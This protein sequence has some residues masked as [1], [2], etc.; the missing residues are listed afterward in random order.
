MLDKDHNFVYAHSCFYTGL[1]HVDDCEAVNVVC[2]VTGNNEGF[3]MSIFNQI[4]TKLISITEAF[5]NDERG[6]TAIEYAV[7]AVAVAAVVLAVFG[8]GADNP[9]QS[10]LTEAMDTVAGQVTTAEETTP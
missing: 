5:K 2:Q 4:G 1:D 9:L 3:N 10:A 8:S 6:V 7:I